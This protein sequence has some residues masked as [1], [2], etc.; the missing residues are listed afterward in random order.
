MRKLTTLIAAALITA[1]PGAGLLAQP[2]QRPLLPLQT[3]SLPDYHAV[4]V[5]DAFTL[6]AAI[7][8]NS[9]AA[10]TTN[11]AGNL[12]VLQRGPIPFLEFA[13]DGSLVR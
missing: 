1:L 8:F 2:P 11:A 9:V 4:D 10:V 12:L 5:S 13:A 6:P 7:E 3:W